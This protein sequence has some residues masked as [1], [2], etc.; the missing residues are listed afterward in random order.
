MNWNAESINPLP[1][2]FRRHAGAAGENIAKA[3]QLFPGFRIIQKAY[4]NSGNGIKPRYS[5]LKNSC[6]KLIHV[7]TGKKNKRSASGKKCVHDMTLSED[8]I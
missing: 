7:E 2:N 6:H 3:L 8:M 5:M 4:E 1:H